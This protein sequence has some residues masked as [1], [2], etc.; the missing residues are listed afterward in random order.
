MPGTCRMENGDWCLQSNASGVNIAA[1]RGSRPTTGAAETPNPDAGVNAGKQH[2][3]GG[4]ME[5]VWICN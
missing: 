1:G 5:C 2:S 3:V 4:F